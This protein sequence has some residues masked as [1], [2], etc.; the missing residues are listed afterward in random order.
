MNITSLGRF[1]SGRC[2]LTNKFMVILEGLSGTLW[3]VSHLP[4]LFISFGAQFVP[5]CE[6]FVPCLISLISDHGWSLIKDIRAG[7]NQGIRVGQGCSF[8]LRYGGCVGIMVQIRPPCSTTINR[9]GS[10]RNGCKLCKIV[11]QDNKGSNISLWPITFVNIVFLGG[12]WNPSGQPCTRSQISISRDSFFSN[13]WSWL[14]VFSGKET[15]SS[16][17]CHFWMPSDLSLWTTLKGSQ[18]CWS[19]V[20][21]GSHGR[22]TIQKFPQHAGECQD[23]AKE[24]RLWVSALPWC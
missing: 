4:L 7:A 10:R 14:Q 17:P 11:K 9:E 22:S 15:T 2:H 8:L 18:Y 24:S 19:N 23:L 3:Q 13:Q 1:C 5:R 12:I 21:E 20:N 16:T 6:V